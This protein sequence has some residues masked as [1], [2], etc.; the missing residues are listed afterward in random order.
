MLKI[1][2]GSDSFIKNFE[3]NMLA[4]E[5]TVKKLE[6]GECTLEE[7]IKLFEDGMAY[8]KE[9]RKALDTAEIKITKLAETNDGVNSDD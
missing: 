2:S 8:A 4:L 9:C 6:N 1:L 5:E 3:K 7:S